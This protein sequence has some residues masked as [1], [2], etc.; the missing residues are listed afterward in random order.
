MY[1]LVME[2]CNICNGVIDKEHEAY[3][4]KIVDGKAEYWHYKCSVAEPHEVVQVYCKDRVKL[5]EFLGTLQTEDSDWLGR[6]KVSLNCN[7]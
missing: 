5:C 3:S 4:Y 6:V 1:T 2:I 7:E